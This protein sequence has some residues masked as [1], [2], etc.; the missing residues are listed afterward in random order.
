M[1]PRSS[2]VSPRSSRD[3]L[4][5]VVDASVGIKLFIH[6]AGSEQANL[7]F[8]RLAVN[9]PANLYIPDLFYAECA[10]VLW[11]YV[12][13]YGYAA[14]AARQNLI[15]LQALALQT[16]PTASLVDRALPLALEYGVTVYDACYLALAQLAGAPLVTADTALVKKMQ[17]AGVE[18]YA[19]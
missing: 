2:G 17:G 15:D 5:C 16:V 6:E 7:I 19:L 8:Q 12:R 13:Q 1:S 14:E 9:P 11:K 3:T 18:V 4:D 10:Y